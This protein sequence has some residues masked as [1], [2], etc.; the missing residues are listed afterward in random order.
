MNKYSPSPTVK[1]FVSSG[2]VAS[3][4]SLSVYIYYIQLK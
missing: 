3:K 4:E 2:T 1:Y